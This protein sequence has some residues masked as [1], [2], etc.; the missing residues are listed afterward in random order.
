MHLIIESYRST[1]VARMTGG[2][3]THDVLLQL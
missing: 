2:D 1:V 3:D